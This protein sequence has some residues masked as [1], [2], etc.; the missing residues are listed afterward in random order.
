VLLD[1][2]SKNYESARLSKRKQTT[3]TATSDAILLNMT[4]MYHCNTSVGRLSV[5]DED[6]VL[7]AHSNWSTKCEMGERG[8][9]LS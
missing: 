4:I 5:F 7:K 3:N 8:V 6:E 2:V 9:L 1:H